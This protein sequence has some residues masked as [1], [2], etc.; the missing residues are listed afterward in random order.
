MYSYNFFIAIRITYEELCIYFSNIL[1]PPKKFYQKLEISIFKKS[2]NLTFLSYSKIKNSILTKTVP[3]RFNF[4]FKEGLKSKI[5]A[6]LLFQMLST[7]TKKQKLHIIVK[8]IHSSLLL[9]DRHSK[10]HLPSWYSIIVIIKNWCSKK[11][12]QLVS[13][14]GLEQ[15]G[16]SFYNRLTIYTFIKKL[17]VAKRKQ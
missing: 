10:R 4:L 17:R 2:Q 14:N 3:T 1:T 11:K 9:S 13:N 16:P 15:G 6:F 8:S 7:D 5:E 12:L